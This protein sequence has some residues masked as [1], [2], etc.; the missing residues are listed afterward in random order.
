MREVLGRAEVRRHEREHHPQANSHSYDVRGPR[1][2]HDG[3]VESEG[4][5]A[6]VDEQGP[7]QAEQAA[8]D[9]VYPS[10]RELNAPDT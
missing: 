1:K 9:F 8:A 4:D 3:G 5:E 2:L 7:A 6:G 10:S